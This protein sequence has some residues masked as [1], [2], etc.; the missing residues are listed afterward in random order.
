M[1]E[2]VASNQEG[3][4]DATTRSDLRTSTKA[5]FDLN[6]KQRTVEDARSDL[7]AFHRAEIGKSYTRWKD[8][9]GT[10]HELLPFGPTLQDHHETL[11]EL[12]GITEP[13]S[14]QES[15][16][17]VWLR[18]TPPDIRRYAQWCTRK[19]PPV[20]DM[21]T[22]EEVEPFRVLE[23]PMVGMVEDFRD[24]QMATEEQQ[25]LAMTIANETLLRLNAAQA[26]RIDSDE[27]EDD[28]GVDG[29]GN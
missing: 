9:D 19:K 24:K 3:A 20:I 26:R 18:V 17:I 14:L 29:P 22:F 8:A 16:I 6:P 21:E 5:E 25:E 1:I 2:E 12:I 28:E 4:K 15:A 11:R 10:F 7:A 23:C 27:D 13:N